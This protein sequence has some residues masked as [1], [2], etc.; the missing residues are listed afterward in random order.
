VREKEVEGVIVA[1]GDREVESVLERVGEE[2][3]TR[4]ALEERL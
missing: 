2:L 3:G 1:E 4:L